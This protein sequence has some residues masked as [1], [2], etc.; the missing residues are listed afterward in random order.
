MGSRNWSKHLR[1]SK[2]EHG[3][4]NGGK[5]LQQMYRKH[6]ILTLSCMLGKA[7]AALV[8]MHVPRE[9]VPSALISFSPIASLA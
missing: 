7:A 1:P 8:F 3:S 6:S 2:Q 9:K 4:W 5:D